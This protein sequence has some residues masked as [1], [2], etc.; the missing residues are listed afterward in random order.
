MLD[1]LGADRSNPEN[2]PIRLVDGLPI[3]KAAP[4]LGPSGGQDARPRTDQTDTKDKKGTKARKTRKDAK[5]RPAKWD[6]KEAERADRGPEAPG[7]SKKVKATK[8][9]AVE[10]QGL[11]GA[12]MQLRNRLTDLHSVQLD[13]VESQAALS[14]RVEDLGGLVAALRGRDERLVRRLDQVAAVVEALG[15]RVDRALPQSPVLEGLAARVAR[16]ES[17]LTVLQDQPDPGETADRVLGEVEGRLAA[18]RVLL[19]AQV[20]RLERLEHDVRSPRTPTDPEETSWRPPLEALSREL[21]GR[22][23]ALTQ[24]LQRE[25]RAGRADARQREEGIR[26]WTRDRLGRMERRHAL[27]LGLMGVLLGVL[28]AAG[29]WRTEQ[30]LT[31]GADRLE[32]LEQRLASVPTPEPVVGPWG[33]QDILERLRLLESG[34]LEG[35]RDLA[36]TRQAAAGVAGQLTAL[37]EGQ[38]DLALRLDRLSRDLSAA[39]KGLAVLG[40]RV[41]GL[42]PVV[43]APLGKSAG[44]TPS[45]PSVLAEPGYAVQ[46]VA[47]LGRTPIAPFVQRFGVADRAR[48][49]AIR[50]NGR[51]AYAVLLGP[52]GSEPEAR[53]AIGSLPPDLRSLGPWVRRL[54][55]GTR[56]EPW[57]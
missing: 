41:S 48:V 52:F 21:D 51:S 2:R 17:A 1:H 25:S 47:Y 40:E 26:S 39:D 34:A 13:Q 23:Q 19:D 45:D 36:T 11:S 32:S 15:V 3:P 24:G 22:I 46:L 9:L 37:T 14:R 55:A 16:A 56:L 33:A 29:W 38:K 50:I 30:I 20:G 10:L 6:R 4:D 57:G 8:R 44:A 5:E 12:L 54:P 53:E 27:A 35:A 28:A 43:P 31:G 18:L 7:H 42:T 49:A